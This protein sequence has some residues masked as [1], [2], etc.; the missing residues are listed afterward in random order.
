MFSGRGGNLAPEQGIDQLWGVYGGFLYLRAVSLRIEARYYTNGGRQLYD[1]QSESLRNRVSNEV[2]V[3]RGFCLE[4]PEV[5]IFA[6]SH[7]TAF[8][9]RLRLATSRAK[10]VTERHCL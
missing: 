7:L 1:W 4:A 2:W 8:P 3:A 6:D 9:F 10:V 5:I